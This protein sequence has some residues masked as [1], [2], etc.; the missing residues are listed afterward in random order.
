MLENLSFL[1]FEP[2][3]DYADYRIPVKILNVSLALKLL[4][5]YGHNITR[6]LPKEQM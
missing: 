5:K 3:L 1:N 4:L 2:V 6:F